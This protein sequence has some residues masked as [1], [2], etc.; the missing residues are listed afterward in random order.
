MKVTITEEKGI[1]WHQPDNSLADQVVIPG[2]SEID[3]EAIA[4]AEKA[5]SNL[6]ASFEDWMQEECENLTR[7]CDIIHQEGPNSET[8]ERLFHVSHDIKGQAATLGY[9]LA[10]GP[11]TSLCKLVY[12]IPRPERGPVALIDQ[13]VSAI[14][15]VVRD[16]IQDVNHQTSIEISR[17]L[18]IVTD[19]FLRQEIDIYARKMENQSVPDAARE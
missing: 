17:R 4:R 15:A 7:A 8:L 16:K 1:E 10:A 18:A 11:A 13:H 14:C 12:E 9:P 19:D 5:L 6:S 3:Y 2:T